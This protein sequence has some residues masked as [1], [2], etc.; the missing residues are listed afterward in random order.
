M[1]DIIFEVFTSLQIQ[2]LKSE[3]ACG[4]ALLPLRGTG[5]A[6]LRGYAATAGHGR[7]VVRG[8]LCGTLRGA[9]AELF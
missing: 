1:I 5:A 9:A 3:C 7:C 4:H 8:A 6:P 2:N